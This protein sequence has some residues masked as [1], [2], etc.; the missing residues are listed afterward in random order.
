MNKTDT[1]KKKQM[2]HTKKKLKGKKNVRFY[3]LLFPIK[4]KQR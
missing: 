4:I 3:S 1:I 2:K